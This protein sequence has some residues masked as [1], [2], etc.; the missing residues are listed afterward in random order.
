MNLKHNV[1]F[2]RNVLDKTWCDNVIKKYKTYAVKKGKI[3]GDG[4]KLKASE[5]KKRRNSSIA[6]VG[7]KEIYQKIDPY[8]H[9]AN[10]NSGWNFEVSWY[11]EMQFTKYSK[12]QYYNWHMDMFPQP[13]TKHRFPQYEGKIRKISCS[14]ILNDP[15]EYSGG[16][17]E[18]GHTNNFETSLNKNKLNLSKYNLGQG[19]IIFFPGFIWHRVT[20]VTKGTRYSLVMWTIGKPYV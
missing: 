16:D 1:W 18:I 11:E 5:N 13:Y 20:P 6:W 3:G 10:K 19:S 4:S 9:T 17:L 8:V 15:K 7:D 2:F 14:V 12:G